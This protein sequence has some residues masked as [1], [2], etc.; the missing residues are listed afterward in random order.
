[1]ANKFLSDS[2]GIWL[3]ETSNRPTLFTRPVLKETGR[4]PYEDPKQMTRCGA[5]VTVI[6]VIQ[7]VWEEQS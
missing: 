2:A 5:P 1:M 3:L 7:A 6:G 4:E